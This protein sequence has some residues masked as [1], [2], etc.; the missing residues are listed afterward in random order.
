MT[1]CIDATDANGP[2]VAL[3]NNGVELERLCGLAGM[4]QA[5]QVLPL[6]DEVLSKTGFSLDNVSEIKVN[7]GPGSFTGTRVGV[8]LANALALALRL[9]VNGQPAGSFV[10]PVYD[11]APKITAPKSSTK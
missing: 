9:P 7:T 3:L 6:I 10:A 5:Q 4:R 2:E 11:S 8:A 1:L